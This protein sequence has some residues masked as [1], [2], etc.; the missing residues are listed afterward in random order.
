MNESKKLTDTQYLNSEFLQ[1]ANDG[2]LIGK[3]DDVVATLGH[4]KLIQISSDGL[5]MNCKVSKIIVD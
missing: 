2:Q 3:F 1:G 5:S 4:S